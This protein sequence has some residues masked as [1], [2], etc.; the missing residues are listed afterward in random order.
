MAKAKKTTVATKSKKIVEKE[1]S[2]RNHAIT[3]MLNDVEFDAYNRYCKQFKVKNKSKMMREMILASMWKDFNGSY[4]T[5]FD[6]QELADLVIE[7]R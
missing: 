1:K 7:R 5:L 2:V 4:P 3:T 6:K